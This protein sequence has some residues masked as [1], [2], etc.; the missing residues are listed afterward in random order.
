MKD[1]K[2]SDQRSSARRGLTVPFRLT[3]RGR[4]SQVIDGETIDISGEGVG[5]KFA[6]SGRDK[7]DSLLESLVEDRVA[8][9]LTLRLPEGSVTSTGQVMWWGL[10]GDDSKFSVRAGILL[11]KPWSDADWLL[12]DKN[13]GST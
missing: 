6:S 13:L 2:V 1:T 9:E 8:V 11:P 7:L 10:L 5:I 4:L 12:I 3:T